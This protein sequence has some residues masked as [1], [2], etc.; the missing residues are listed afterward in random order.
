MLLLARSVSPMN[1][2][3]LK[4][5]VCSTYMPPGVP[6][7]N[8]LTVESKLAES[9]PCATR[10][11]KRVVFAYSASTCKGYVSPLTPANSVMSASVMVL[12]NAA[13]SPTRKLA[14]SRSSCATS[15]TRRRHDEEAPHDTRPFSTPHRSPVLTADAEFRTVANA[16]FD[17]WQQQPPYI[18]Y[19]VDVDVNV[20]A[21]KTSR[22]VSRAVEARTSDDLAVLQDLPQGQNQ[23]GHAFPVPPTFDALSYF[24]LDFHLGDPV[25]LH[26]PL[27]AVTMLAPEPNVPPRPLYYTDPAPSTPGAV[28]AITLR[29]YYAQYADDSNDRIAHIVMQAL[30]GL[31]GGHDSSFYLHDLYVDTATN[32]PT[33]IVYSGP[34]TDF[35][36]DYTVVDGHWLIDHLTYRRSVVAPFH[37]GSTTFTT[38]ARYGGFTFPEVPADGRLRRS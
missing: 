28:V 27:T 38:E 3:R 14:K 21:M 30:P 5:S 18:A 25:R 12:L 33:R 26:N 20:P 6:S 7:N 13:E 2:G 8:P 23:L 19:R 24:R 29:N 10:A 35:A 9:M 36:L 31:P 15:K 1:T 4:R 16:A 17:A 37:I 11:P 22:H 34:D 32:L